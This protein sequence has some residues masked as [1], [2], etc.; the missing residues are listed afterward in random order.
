MCHEQPILSIKKLWYIV[1]NMKKLSTTTSII[2][3]AIVAVIGLVGLAVWQNIKPSPYVAFAQCLSDKGATVYEAW[4]CPHCQDQK[5]MF[6]SAAKYLNTVECGTARGQISKELCPDVRATPTWTDAEGN[7][8]EG[9]RSL[10]N[11]G[12]LYGCELPE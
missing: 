2:L 10:E 4:W 11:L 9:A 7:S 6:G 5:A 3:L 1:I 12:E 8:Y